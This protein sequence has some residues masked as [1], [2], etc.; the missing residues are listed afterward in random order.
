MGDDGDADDGETWVL[1][2]ALG[3][4]AGAESVAGAAADGVDVDD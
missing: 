3:R 4:A 2:V 1:A